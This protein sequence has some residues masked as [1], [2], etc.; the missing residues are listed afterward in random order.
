MGDGKINMDIITTVRENKILS[1]K[2]LSLHHLKEAVIM[3]MVKMTIININQIIMK[4]TNN[5]NISH[6]R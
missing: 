5:Y 3:A 6:G 1:Q 4:M 2:M